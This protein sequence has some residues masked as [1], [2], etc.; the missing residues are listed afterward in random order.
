MAVLSAAERMC[1]S[2]QLSQQLRGFGYLYT[3]LRRG[4]R[5][6]VCAHAALFYLA[7]SQNDCT[8]QKDVCMEEAALQVQQKGEYL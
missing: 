7:G 3:Q 4:E 5:E 8:A 2:R 1:S 6:G